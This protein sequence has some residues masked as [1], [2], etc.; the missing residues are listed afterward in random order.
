MKLLISQNWFL[1]N[2]NVE[3]RIGRLNI[4]W[5]DNQINKYEDYIS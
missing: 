3:R 5:Y 1:K 2:R 4:G